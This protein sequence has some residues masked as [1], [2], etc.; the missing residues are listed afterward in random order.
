MSDLLIWY[1]ENSYKVAEKVKEWVDEII[2]SHKK[3]IP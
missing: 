1:V 2:R 3:V